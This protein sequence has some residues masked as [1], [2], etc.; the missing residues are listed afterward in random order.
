MNVRHNPS[1]MF[2]LGLL[3]ESFPIVFSHG[4]FI[5]PPEHELLKQYNHFISITPESEMHYGH[6]DTDSDFVM[7]HAS[8]GVDTHSTFSG[9][10]VGQARIWL[11]SVRHR[12][13]RK[14]L[15]R[16]LIPSTNP[17]SVKQAFHL[18][19]R[20]GAQALRRDDLGVIRVGA[21]A[22]IVVFDGTSTNMVGWRDPVAAIILHSHVSDVVHVMVDGKLVKRDGKLVAEDLAN[23]T[24]A[25]AQSAKRIQ[26]QA[27]EAEFPPAEGASA[28]GIYEYEPTD[29][30][31]ALRGNGTGY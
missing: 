12:L 7:D 19:P 5:T 3:N 15:D 24:Q 1:L 28:F 18:A 20:G 2:S 6:T 31:D 21:K 9:D 4:S 8:L 13:Y 29:I 23:V 30:V 22:D 16:W 25:F 26:D 10:I 17:M 14:V 11:Q 27:V